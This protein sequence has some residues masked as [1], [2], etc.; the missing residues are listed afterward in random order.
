[1]SRLGALIVSTESSSAHLSCVRR[2][3]EGVR[4]DV[5]FAMRRAAGFF[6]GHEAV[7]AD[8]RRL[9]YGEAWGRGVRLANG[10]IGMGLR[11]GDRVGVLEDNGL[12]ASDFLLACAIANV[13]RVPLYARNSPEAHAH[14]LG[15]TNARVLVVAD[16]YAHEVKSL[17]DELPDL[18]HVLVRDDGYEAFL[19]EQSAEDPDVPV[20]P[21]DN[22]IIRHTGGTTGKAKGAAY[23]HRQWLA[24][25]RNWFYNYPPIE[26]GDGCLHVGPISHASGY[27][28]LPIWMA[29]GRNILMSAF[30]PGAALTLLEQER[31]CYLLGVPAVLSA[32]VQYPGATE[33]DY[34][35]LKVICVGA[36]PVTDDTALKALDV[37]GPVL[38]HAY[39]QTEIVPVTMINSPEWYAKVEGSNPLRSVGRPM[40]YT[41]VEIRD[42]ETHETLPIGEEGEIAAKSDGQISGFWNNPEATVE[43]IVDGWVLTG[44]LGRMDENGYVYLLDRKDDMIISG[45]YNIYPAELE[46]IICEHPAVIAAA[47]F[48]IPDER[49]GETPAAVCVVDDVNKVVEQEIIDLCANRLGSYKKPGKVVIQTDPLPLSPVGKVSRKALREPYW[50]GRESR[51]SGN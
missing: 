40:P 10:L 13:V 19:A 21:D 3:R 23:T 6:S 17:V 34:S 1:M 50:A 35:T 15:H 32:L 4:M 29:G 18:E 25:A 22:Y 42:P 38:S 16:H 46:N 39:G 45:G 43:R 2:L 26:I 31:I 11:P 30:E 24:T 14:M 8:D 9:T 12:H 49:W 20:D 28:F 7:V 37:F 48:A 51:I 36:A 47:V 27:F 44:D 5:R 33:H 41:L